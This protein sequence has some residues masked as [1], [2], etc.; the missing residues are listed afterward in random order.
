MTDIKTI[1]EVIEGVTAAHNH[2]L[3]F[4]LNDTWNSRW[5][6]YRV[7]CRY[8]LYWFDVFD[9]VSWQ[10]LGTTTR[11]FIPTLDSGLRDKNSL[12][13]WHKS[14]VLHLLE[15]LTGDKPALA[16]G[17][18]FEPVVYC[19]CCGRRLYSPRYIVIGR[20]PECNRRKRK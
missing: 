16:V 13:W 17:L 9:G 12:S 11:S 15:C 3:Q 1:R 4:Q 6:E 18:H 2:T 20:G 8:N 7:K 14:N 19:D 10:H 5:G